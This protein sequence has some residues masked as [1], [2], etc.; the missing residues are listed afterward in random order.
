MTLQPIR[1]ANGSVDEQSARRLIDA[2]RGGTDLET[3]C[4]YAGQS[5][6]AVSELIAVGQAESDRIEAGLEPVESNATALSLWR[7]VYK[8]RAESIV[9]AVAQIQKAANQGDWKAAAW[10]LER[11]MPA[12]YAIKERKVEALPA[13]EYK[14]P[15]DHVV[16]VSRRMED[17]EEIP[18]CGICKETMKRLF[19]FGGVSFKGT[20]WASKPDAPSN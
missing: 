4:A 14:C 10:W 18:T 16:T 1:M 6:S 15:N 13:Y 8:A 9:R 19:D 5:L 20:G 11:A 17:K 7:E 12:T 2:M 3:A